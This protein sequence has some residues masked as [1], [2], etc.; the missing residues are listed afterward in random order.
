MILPKNNI[1]KLEKSQYFNTTMKKFIG[2]RVGLALTS[3]DKNKEQLR[4]ADASHKN[5]TLS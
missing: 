2:T 4:M 3:L 1:A 5:L